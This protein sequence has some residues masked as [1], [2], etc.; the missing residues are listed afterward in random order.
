MILKTNALTISLFRGYVPMATYRALL[1]DREREVL[2]GEADVSQNYVYQI[3]SRV[4]NKIDRLATERPVQTVSNAAVGHP[5]GNLF[6]I[7]PSCVSC[8][9][10]DEV[11]LS[12]R[13]YLRVVGASGLAGL[14]GCGSR[15]GTAPTQPEST[16]RNDHGVS[17]TSTNGDSATTDGW[18]VDPVEHDK[19]VGAYY[20]QWYH[21]EAG[22]GLHD[23]HPWLE[24]V[25]ATP[26]LGQYHSRDEDV[27]NQH[28][29]WAL[30]HG[31][32]WFM[33][34]G[35][36]PGG[37]DELTLRNHV[38]EAAL[39]AQMQFSLITGVPNRFRQ[40]GQYD[41]DDPELRRTVGDQLARFE[42]RYFDRENY[43]TI[44]GAPVVMY[45]AISN[46]AGDVAGAWEEIRGMLDG[47]VYLIA[48]PHLGQSPGMTEAVS[49]A[50]ELAEA[51]DAFTEYN[52]NPI[53]QNAYG[54]FREADFERHYRDWR[55]AAAEYGV[56]FIPMTVPGEDHSDIDWKEPRDFTLER[57]PDRFRRLCRDALRSRDADIDA[58]LVTS[59][60][61][62]PEFTSVEPA[63]AY[64][65]TYL[66]I[67]EEE[68]ARND[69]EPLP[70]DTYATLALE[71]NAVIP[72]Q[73]VNPAAGAN[74]LLAFQFDSLTVEALEGN[75][76]ATYDIG[77]PAEEPIFTEGV[78]PPNRNPG[79]GMSAARWL[80]GT[81]ERAIIHV[82]PLEGQLGNIRLSGRPITTE[83]EAA[84]RF[85][86]E[87][88]GQISFD[89]GLADYDIPVA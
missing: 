44:D 76:V 48:D 86:G 40:D 49:P 35:A 37:Y 87:E 21:G 80:G 26:E 6:L 56:D 85:N 47:D 7:N 33:A 19:L 3:P 8:A 67:V 65:T 79:S 34:H 14:A 39:A 50:W 4:R 38:M 15:S 32:N 89:G 16:D 52:M 83:I 18:A 60:N 51:F 54:E 66:E 17:T 10:D 78:Y 28:I 5:P 58:V 64:G 69:R 12:R 20:Y 41:M 13:R 55:V 9:M 31:I 36:A 43:L 63:E 72:E 27:I 81:T 77:L 45:Y 68:L 57:K 88:V 11:S 30:E 59:F 61:E 23:E 70:V 24:H 82:E 46:L 73:E 2:S 53:L 25:P 75:A 84:V 42:D 62:W 1:T 74:R 71:F 29:K 22:Y